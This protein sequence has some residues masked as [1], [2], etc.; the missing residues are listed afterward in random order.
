MP[1]PLR[2]CLNV[3]QAWRNIVE[4]ATCLNHKRLT[5]IARAARSH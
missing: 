3:I 1:M 4:G 5:L 2:L